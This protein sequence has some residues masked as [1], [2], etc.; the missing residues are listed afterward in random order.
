VEPLTPEEQSTITRYLTRP[1][2][3]RLDY[4]SGYT[5]YIVPSFLFALYGVWK[6][7]FVAVAFAYLALLIMIVYIIFYQASSSGIFYSA[8]KKLAENSGGEAAPAEAP[9][10]AD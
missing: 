5:A 7:D 8:I 9:V 4:F 3:G 1:P 10:D 6:T 2:R